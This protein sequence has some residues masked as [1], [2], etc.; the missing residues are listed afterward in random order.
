MFP[1]REFKSQ[2]LK[3]LRNLNVS[4][5]TKTDRF[6]FEAEA[7]QNAGTLSTSFHGANLTA[8]DHDGFQ[9][10]F[11]ALTLSTSHTFGVSGKVSTIANTAGGTLTI[12]NVTLNDKLTF[13]GFN[14]LQDVKVSDMKVVGGSPAYV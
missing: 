7:D 5:E 10:F 12:S 13:A 4:F 9:S 3:V 8:V 1:S 14:G 11:K 2:C 6:Y